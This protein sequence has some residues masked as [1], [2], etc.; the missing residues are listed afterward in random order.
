MNVSFNI[1]HSDTDGIQIIVYIDGTAYVASE[2]H[3]LFKDILK[4]CRELDFENLAQ[5]FDVKGVLTE[6]LSQLSERVR[7]SETT[8]YFDGEPMFGKLTTILVN[9]YRDGRDFV[10]LLN[11]L[12]NLM[13]N[14]SR[15]SREQLYG[16][17]E[18]HHFS[19]TSDGHFLA[20]KG[21][22]SDRHSL[23]NGYGIVDGVI[24]HG[25]LP[26]KDGSIIEMGR[27]RVVEDPNQGCT[28][29][30]HV[31]TYLYASSYGYV[32]VLVKVNPRDVVSVPI[33]SD[34]QKLRVTRYK[35]L[36]EVSEEVPD[37]YYEDT[38]LIPDD[39]YDDAELI[40]EL[41][42]DR[43]DD[44]LVDMA[45][46]TLEEEASNYTY[47][48]RMAGSY[49]QLAERLGFSRDVAEYLDNSHSANA[50]YRYHV[51]RLRDAYLSE[52]D[53]DEENNPT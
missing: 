51:D 39:E 43:V 23:H 41:S 16:F 35:V 25:T 36:H 24:T 37:D 13:N 2:S 22:N 29:G 50:V 3:L 47:K 38:M 5:L 34:Y 1:T 52:G 30:L 17:L 45:V 32:T 42:D 28:V 33:D 19:I 40:P 48:G 27:D 44:L 4:A 31:G 26:N 6:T 11:F 20:Y 21:V 53:G 15:G 18:H 49:K 8:L 10:P 7:I 12:E 14:P 46:S 9:T